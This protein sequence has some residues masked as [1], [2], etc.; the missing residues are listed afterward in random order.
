[1][2]F[3]DIGLRNFIAGGNRS[4]DIEKVME[5]VVY[6]ELADDGFT[7]NVGQL[8]A[9]EIDFVCTRPN[10]TAYVQVSYIIGDSLTEKREFGSLK[11]IKDSYPKY[12]ISLTPMVRRS[13]YEGITHL[14]LREF[15]TNGL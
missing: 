7:V 5:N 10:R 6:N 11:K 2:Y 1:M 4:S 8:R 3:E 9:G 13:D 14:G 12:V 15:L